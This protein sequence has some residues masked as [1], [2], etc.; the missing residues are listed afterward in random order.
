MKTIN[1]IV[2]LTYVGFA[3]FFYINGSQDSTEQNRGLFLRYLLP[4]YIGLSGLIIIMIECRFGFMVRNLSFLYNYFGRG[5]FNLY[6]GG[7]PLMLVQD[8]SSSLEIN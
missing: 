1:L 2:G 5:I 6:A 7:M 8:W 3:V 4:A